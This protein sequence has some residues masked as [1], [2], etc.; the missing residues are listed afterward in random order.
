MGEQNKTTAKTYQV[1][2]TLNAPQNINEITGY[3]AFINHQPL[4]AFKVGDALF[5]TIYR[6]A[7]NPLVFRQCEEIPTKGKIYRKAICYSWC[8]VY[9]IKASEIV[10]LGVIHGSRRPFKIRKLRKIK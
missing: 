5:A 9:R 1:K 4:N 10:I 3:I 7:A 2:L 8:I 6:I